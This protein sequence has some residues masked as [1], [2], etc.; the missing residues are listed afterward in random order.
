MFKFFKKKNKNKNKKIDAIIYPLMTESVY[1]KFLPGFSFKESHMS[2]EDT[3]ELINYIKN[4]SDDILPQNINEDTLVKL[5]YLDDEF[6][7]WADD[8]D[9]KVPYTHECTIPYLSTLGQT[10]EEIDANIER[11]WKKNRTDE[12]HLFLIPLYMENEISTSECIIDN[13]PSEIIKDALKQEGF[14]SWVASGI[15]SYSDILKYDKQIKSVGEEN[16][17]GNNVRF[18]MLDQKKYEDGAVMFVP[19][20]IK[21]DVPGCTISLNVKKNRYSVPMEKIK[22]FRNNI[23]T[24]TT[25]ITPVTNYLISP[26][27]INNLDAVCTKS[28]VIIMKKIL[29]ED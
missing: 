12:Y 29:E 25:K 13:I 14:D 17:K 6:E 7:K 23:K 3:D 27:D 19:C 26:Y 5:L 11:L 9:I 8:H 21:E 20:V 16:L 15:M 24:K 1:Q 18:G 22:E 2:V 10:K 28:S 4:Y